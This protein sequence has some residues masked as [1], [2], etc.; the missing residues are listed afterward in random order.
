M[1][2]ARIFIDL[3]LG[4]GLGEWIEAIMLDTIYDFQFGYG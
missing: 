2:K 4:D 1:S 3:T